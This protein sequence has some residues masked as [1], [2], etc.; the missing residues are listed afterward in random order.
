MYT[1]CPCWWA[2]NLYRHGWFFF[3]FDLILCWLCCCFLL[4]FFFLIHFFLS[5]CRELSVPPRGEK[6]LHVGCLTC[7]VRTAGLH[8]QNGWMFKGT[9][10]YT[11]SDYTTAKYFISHTITFIKPAQE[12]T[13]IR[14]H[15]YASMRWWDFF[16]SSPKASEYSDFVHYDHRCLNSVAV[17]TSPGQLDGDERLLVLIVSFFLVHHVYYSGFWN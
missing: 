8:P 4:Q 17:E 6:T 7:T 3:C 1:C 14:I 13:L 2:L 16:F 9:T 12:P 15:S 11:I 10:A 5:M